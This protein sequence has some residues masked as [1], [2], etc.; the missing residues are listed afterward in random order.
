MQPITS[1]LLIP[2]MTHEYGRPEPRRNDIGRGKPKNSEKNLSQC[3]LNLPKKK[4]Q[5]YLIKSGSINM[6]SH[7]W[8]S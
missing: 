6:S 4:H 5:L 2:Q 1:Y 7:V 3:D 8:Q